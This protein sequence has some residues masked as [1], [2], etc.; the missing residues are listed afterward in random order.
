MSHWSN[1]V[2]EDVDEALRR[3]ES[4]NRPM[5]NIDF[6]KPLKIIPISRGVLI[7][8]PGSEGDFSGAIACKDMAEVAAVLLSASYSV[9]P[10]PKGR[11]LNES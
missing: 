7:W 6:G 1:A 4:D 9:E 2:L 8:F 10:P 3:I 5:M 11:A